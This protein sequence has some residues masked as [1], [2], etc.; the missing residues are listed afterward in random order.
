MARA[1]R[2]LG[3]EGIEDEVKMVCFFT[4]SLFSGILGVLVLY[5]YSRL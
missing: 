2:R 4:S 1:T 5:Q 3:F